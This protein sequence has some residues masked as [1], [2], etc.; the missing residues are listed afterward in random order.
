M[1]PE[2]Q[3]Y[4]PQANP[5]R[6]RRFITLAIAL[7]IGLALLLV[8]WWLAGRAYIVVRVT[9]TPTTATI[10]YTLTNQATGDSITIE[11]T[12]HEIKQLVPTGEYEVTV[13]QAA[14]NGFAITKAGR[15]LQTSEVTIRLE[16]EK[17]RTF[18]GENPSPCMTYVAGTLLSYSCGSTLP[19]LQAH[20]PATG[21]RPTITRTNPLLASDSTIE[22]TITLGGTT[23]ILLREVFSGEV[24]TY[25][26]VLYPLDSDLTFDDGIV[27]QGL[28]AD[29]YYTIAPFESGFIA[30]EDTAQKAF[31]FASA[32]A[33]PATLDPGRPAQPDTAP[34]TLQSDRNSFAITYSE[35]ADDGET[36]N[37]ADPHGEH[38]H[39]TS[40]ISLYTKEVQQVFSFN[41]PYTSALPCG[42]ERLC[43]IAN[44]ILDV[45]AI[46]SDAPEIMFSITGVTTVLSG[47]NETVRV[48]REQ[49]VLQLN[50]ETQ[51]GTIMYN[52]GDYT[53]CGATTISEGLLLCV[54][55]EGS[56]SALLI[57]NDDVVRHTIDK[58]VLE[59]RK[60]ELINSVSA[61]QNYI[62]IA[63]HVSKMRFNAE[64]REFEYDPDEKKRVGE[65][66]NKA[67]RASGIDT[68]TYE[69]INVNP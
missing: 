30:Y 26:H 5:I 8:V 9:D 47:P 16:P 54:V 28:D 14:T 64:T 35:E 68:D 31:Y 44:K 56:K 36:E 53:Y 37:T 67:I 2:Q 46:N 11:S 60:S 23:H 52:F 4:Y 61:Y 69:V 41:K 43:A 50:L 66:I 58:Q 21:T 25:Q 20:V 18:V 19:S 59:L 62:H 55:G 42:K 3:T 51:S 7:T 34:I 12:D 15:F 32:D 17:S 33:E 65:E 24:Y 63:P 6:N 39:G 13:N 1:H 48:I 40:W 29:A 10:T 22:G 45:Y 49:D 27:L 38:T 57:S